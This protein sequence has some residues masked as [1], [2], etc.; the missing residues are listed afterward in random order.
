MNSKPFENIEN[1][2]KYSKINIEV[3]PSLSI[4]NDL[5]NADREGSD[6]CH[7]ITK[8]NFEN[9]EFSSPKE[10]D[11]LELC[12]NNYS[13]FQEILN[14][15]YVAIA[16]DSQYSYYQKSF[17]NLVKLTSKKSRTEEEEKKNNQ[18]IVDD[19]DSPVDTHEE[20]FK[21]C[22]LTNYS[23]I[24]RFKDREI[25][26]YSVYFIPHSA[27]EK[28]DD[29]L[30]KLEYIVQIKPSENSSIQEIDYKKERENYFEDLRLKYNF[31]RLDINKTFLK[32]RDEFLSLANREKYFHIFLDP[33]SN[34]IINPKLDIMVLDFH[35]INQLWE[36]SKISNINNIDPSIT[37]INELNIDNLQNLSKKF[38]LDIKSNTNISQYPINLIS[39]FNSEDILKK[40]NLLKN[41]NEMEIGRNFTQ[42]F[43]MKNRDNNLSI[44]SGIL[45]IYGDLCVGSF[46]F[47]KNF[48]GM[49]IYSNDFTP[50]GIAFNCLNDN[51]SNMF[52]APSNPEMEN[53]FNII[54]PFS[55]IGV[56]TL[57][58]KYL[59]VDVN[60]SQIFKKCL[61][62]VNKLSKEENNRVRLPTFYKNISD[63]EER[64]LKKIYE[65]KIL[66]KIKFFQG[67][68]YHIRDDESEETEIDEDFALFNNQNRIST[69][70]EDLEKI[71]N[72][73]L[74]E[75]KFDHISTLNSPKNDFYDQGINHFPS[76]GG[77]LN[78]IKRKNV[79][80]RKFDYAKNFELKK[81][82]IKKYEKRSL[83]YEPFNEYFSFK[84]M[85]FKEL[86]NK[87]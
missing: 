61:F 78:I 67:A 28:L 49:I 44:N 80:G 75:D 5:K 54:L 64:N 41:L 72:Q 76:W 7:Q 15:T 86:K 63:D 69:E 56:V 45:H 27:N 9:F 39:Y 34:Q 65:A 37:L 42:F 62:A 81:H 30:K 57:F 84:K 73:Q 21:I 71:L 79:S 22:F 50:L 43:Q 23:L 48:P 11:F 16:I 18:M 68:N 17:I 24:K 38:S 53:N 35:D 47:S 66:Q 55:N 6:F 2:N 29:I 40:I 70:K 46:N 85:E 4:K 59:E 77:N 19:F 51:I 10:Q 33:K 1:K 74:K 20:K 13:L 83:V 3:F 14:K 25:D 58:R 82:L 36:Y 52:K 60:L 32:L 8:F 87:I 12:K 26:Q 31:Q